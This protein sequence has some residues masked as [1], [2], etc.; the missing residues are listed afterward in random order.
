MASHVSRAVFYSDHDSWAVG[1]V[2][3][4]GTAGRRFIG[5]M[6]HP[7]LGNGRGLFLAPCGSIHTLFM[8]FDLDLIF[9]SRDFRV[10]RVVTEVKPWRMA[11]GGWSAWGVLELQSGWFPCAS[12]E[13]GARL[14][15]E[16]PEP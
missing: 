7:P 6:G 11:W 5:L 8:R 1:S 13:P 10:V 16:N 15:F 2:S 4:A 12:L 9:I 14:K 3:L